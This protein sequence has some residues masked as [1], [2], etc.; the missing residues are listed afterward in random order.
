MLKK[1]FE[2]VDETTEARRLKQYRIIIV[3]WLGAESLFWITCLYLKLGCFSAIT[4]VQRMSGLTAVA[5][6][7]LLA[8]VG[9][10]GRGPFPALMNQRA[11]DVAGGRLTGIWGVVFCY[12]ILPFEL[13]ALNTFGVGGLWVMLPPAGVFLGFIGGLDKAAWKKPEASEA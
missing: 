8:V 3:A 2:K 5:V 9:L 10:L 6:M 12:V 1:E 4:A 11:R 7:I 13:F